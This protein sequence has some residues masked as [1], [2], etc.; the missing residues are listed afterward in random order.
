MASSNNLCLNTSKSLEIVFCSKSAK[1]KST[2][3]VPPPLPGIT[4]VD[5]I[6]VLGVTFSNNFSVSAHIDCTLAS[7]HQV[8]FALRTLRFHGLNASSLQAIFTSVALAKLRYASQAWYGFASAADKARLEAFLRK[9]KRFGYFDA[10]GPS[11]DS[12][13]SAADDKLFNS[14]KANPDH[15]LYQ[16]LPAKTNRLY[17]LRPR[18]HNFVLPNRSTSINDCNFIIRMLYK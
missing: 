5:T 1:R 8:F 3:T 12:L 9:G 16:L 2:L 15:V 11:F 10:A 6:N 13:C 18:R 7:C 17:D 14:I 4:R